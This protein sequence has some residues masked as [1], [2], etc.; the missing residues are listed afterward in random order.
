MSS[1]RKHNRNATAEVECLYN[2]TNNE[3]D[4]VS[5]LIYS[6]SFF[7][8]LAPLFLSIMLQCCFGLLTLTFQT[9]PFLFFSESRWS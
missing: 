7:F 4:S 1:K 5:V 2:K 3:T 6:I 8:L 9:I